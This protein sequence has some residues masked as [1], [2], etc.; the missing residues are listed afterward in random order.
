MEFCLIGSGAVRVNP[1]RGGPS[2]IVQISGERLL[3]DC[4]RNAVH[5]LFRFGYPVQDINKVFITHLHFDHVCDL[6]Y[7]ILLS[8]NNGRRERLQFFGPK[9][10]EEFLSVGILKAYSRDIESRLG[11][12][13]DPFGLEW[14]VEEID[15]DGI[16]HRGPDFVLSA[17][18]T[19]H[20]NLLN[21][22]LR[23]DSGDKRLVIT[24]DTRPD[25]RMVEFFENADLLV[26]ECSGTQ[27]FLSTVPWGSWHM[28]PE[29]I[30]EISRRAGVKHVVLKHLVIE[31]WSKDPDISEKMAVTVRQRFNGRVTV[32]YD[33]LTVIL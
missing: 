24:S 2:Q 20:A 29:K 30:G 12:G 11:H 26:S 8:W 7:L 16:F 25:D 1:K 19:D 27:E 4:G 17:L 22:N 10:L 15:S 18:C 6:A 9:G 5:N 33:G 32:G 3:V 31:D 14:S 13:K 28:W 23:I 21:L